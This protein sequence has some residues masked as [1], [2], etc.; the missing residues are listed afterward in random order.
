MI[1]NDNNIEVFDFFDEEGEFFEF[2]PSLEDLTSFDEVDVDDTML[3]NDLI[4]Y[5]GLFSDIDFSDYSGS[6][7]KNM[8]RAVRE[9]KK[10][11]PLTKK[12]NVTR[13]AKI[14]AKKKGVADILV[15]NDRKVIVEGV[16]SFILDKSVSA[17]AI[18]NMGY[19]KG[20]KLRELVLTFNNNSALDFN[21]E[22][23]NPSMPLDYLQSTSLNLNDKIQVAGGG[24]VSYSDILF[25]ILANPTR[26]YQSKFVLAGANLVSQTNQALI[27]K[28]KSI[29][30][31]QKV[32]PF[33][34]GLNIDL[35]QQQNEIIYFDLEQTLNRPFIPD[36]MDVIQYK[37]LA[38]MT[39][40]FGF[41]YSQ[42]SLKK[43]FYKDA[44]E[45]RALM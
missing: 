38:G 2:Q 23:F 12:V 39:V 16:N 1:N 8:R 28:N 10:K 44:K 35:D 31:S 6:F 45:N 7:K 37:V 24:I 3:S 13:S 27:I 21:L 30:G 29:E 40:T 34:M 41:Y 43:F 4:G 5:E 36:G 18:K 32:A 25:N 9:V 20:K 33:Q 14:K 17:D 19:H 26:I 42:V 15:P 22:L 11:K